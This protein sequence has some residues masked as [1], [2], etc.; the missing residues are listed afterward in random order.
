MVF[1][2]QL[3]DSSTIL[4]AFAAFILAFWLFK[5][6]PNLPPGPYGIPLVGCLPYLG[7][8]VFRTG[9]SE[10]H[11][12]FAHLAK[13]YGSIFSMAIT[14]QLVVVINDFYSV[15]EAFRNS[16][17]NDRPKLSLLPEA[18]VGKYTLKR[19]SIILREGI[20]TQLSHFG[21]H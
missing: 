13:R 6:T 21:K 5:Q 2:V 4:I 19:L 20:G 12:L 1:L 15:R 17:L 16:L 7:I 14:T 8:T 18:Q 9:Y 11:R 3:V 10:P